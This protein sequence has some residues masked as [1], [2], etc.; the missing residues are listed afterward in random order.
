MGAH[1]DV[2][3]HVY[4]E[5]YLYGVV[6]YEM[7]DS[8]PIEAL[9][10]QAVAART[11]AS[12]YMGGGGSY[13]LVDTAANQVYKGYNASNTNAIRAVTETAKT[14]L[15][16]DGALVQTFYTA[17]NG[18]YVDIPQHLWSATADIETVPYHTGRPL[19]YAEHV[20]PSGSAHF[21]ENNNGY[22]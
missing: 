21:P 16:C 11:Y 20:E 10:A 14:V 8:W 5:Y 2:I 15:K 7:N 12:R 13:D 4:L 6:P 3:N 19:R 9:K 18:G 1:I 22:R 17:S